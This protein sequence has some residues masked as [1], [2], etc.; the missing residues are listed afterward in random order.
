H[1]VQGGLRVPDLPSTAARQPGPII[2]TWY[3]CRFESGCGANDIVF[4]ASSDGVTWTQPARVPI[5]P[6]GSNVDHFI[7]GFTIQPQ[8]TTRST[9]PHLALGYYYYPVSNCGSS[10]M[11]NVGYVFSA[12]G[13]STWSPPQQLAGPMQLS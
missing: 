3:D 11:L 8:G 9:T 4:S 10:C 13:G 2:T 1:P 6:I 7:P 12:D 5:D